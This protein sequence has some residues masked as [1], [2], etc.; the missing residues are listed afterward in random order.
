M[1]IPHLDGIIESSLTAPDSQPP[2]QRIRSFSQLGASHADIV[3]APSTPSLPYPAYPENVDDICVLANEIIHQPD[4]GMT[5]L[6]ALRFGIDIYTTMNGVVSLELAYGMSTLPWPDQRLL[7][8]DGLLAAKGI[9]D[10][11]PPDLQLG[12]RA[13][14]ADS[15]AG[16]DESALQYV[17]PAWPEPQPAHDVR[18]VIKAQPLRRR[19]LQYDIQRVGIFVSHLATRCHFVDLYFSLRRTHLAEK[20]QHEEE[21]VDPGQE[22]TEE[23]KVQQATEDKEMLESMVEEGDLIAQN[24]LSALS[25]VSQLKLEPNGGWLIGKMRQVAAAL[26]DEAPERR[27]PFVAK[28]A[29]ILAELVELL[30]KMEKTG[31]ASGGGDGGGSGSSAADL[32]QM[33]ADDEADEEQCWAQLREFQLRLAVQ[34]GITES[35]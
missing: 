7:L 30:A 16:L 14:E 6:T 34:E 3:I 24:L 33:T 9:L 20:Q 5:L 19:R 4:G 35:D 1:Y 29:D 32:G 25:S 10:S 17:P 18:N 11:L 23:E 28:T 21:G 13:S 12:H 26:L 22:Q 2:F 15:A 8:R 27:G 31:L